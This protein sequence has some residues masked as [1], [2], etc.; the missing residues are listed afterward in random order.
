VVES[1]L[2]T[3]ER[4]MIYRCVIAAAVVIWGGQGVAIYVAERG[5]SNQ[6]TVDGRNYRDAVRCISVSLT[7]GTSDKAASK[8]A[9]TASRPKVRIVAV[10]ASQLVRGGLD[11]TF[12]IAADGKSPIAFSQSQ[13]RVDLGEQEGSPYFEAKT[14]R[15][16]RETPGVLKV[17]PGKPVVLTV[18]VDGEFGPLGRWGDLPAGR[19]SIGVSVC[20]NTKG[21][22]RFDY[23]WIGSAH[24][25]R[26]P[27][28]RTEKGKADAR[29]R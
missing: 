8:F 15:F 28:L 21:E 17:A 29:E 1:P 24:S 12:E 25:A 7:S 23:H 2:V 16:T 19:Y 3:E 14:L 11:V 22:Q 27:V 4:E 6:P 13:V 10:R 20:G 26:F 5:T 18:G 9:V